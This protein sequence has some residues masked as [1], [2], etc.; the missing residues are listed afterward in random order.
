MLKD[1]ESSLVKRVQKG[2][3]FVLPSTMECLETLWAWLNDKDVN[4]V[5]IVGASG[6]GKSWMVRHIL[7]RAHA[8]NLFE[9]I[10]WAD[11][12]SGTSS[13]EETKNLIFDELDSFGE[14]IDRDRTAIHNV[15]EGKRYLLVLEHINVNDLSDIGI[16]HPKLKNNSSKLVFVG[17]PLT[18]F[19]QDMDKVLELTELSQI[20]AELLFQNRSGIKPDHPDECE[21]AEL[22][23][24]E[25]KRIPSVIVVLAGLVRRNL[26]EP[27]ATVI[28]TLQKAY[29]LLIDQS[30][31]IVEVACEML[32]SKQV[33]DCFLFSITNSRAS[34]VFSVRR[35]IIWWITEGFLDG[36]NCLAE[37]YEKAQDI[38]MTL[39]NCYLL[40][41]HDDDH[42]KL[43]SFDQATIDY[44]VDFE[45]HTFG[46]HWLTPVIMNEN[47]EI[48]YT[49]VT[50]SMILEDSNLKVLLVYGNEAMVPHEIPDVFFEKMEQLSILSLVH[51]GIKSLPSS[52]STLECLGTLLLKDCRS[53]EDVNQIRTLENLAYLR[54]SGCSSLTKLPDETSLESLQYLNLSG[55]SSLTKLPDDLFRNAKF[56]KYL[57][58]SNTQLKELPSSLYD[59]YFLK[60]LNLKGCS[61]LETLSEL[62]YLVHLYLGDC[63]QIKTEL[64]L[65]GASAF[66]EFRGE[67]TGK[68][69]CLMQVD[70]SGTKTAQLQFLSECADLRELRLK[71]CSNIETVPSLSRELEIL[72]LSGATSFKEFENEA[73]GDQ[74]HYLDLSGTQIKELPMISVESNLIQLLLKGCPDLKELPHLDLQKLEVLNLSGSIHFK[75]FSSCSL[76]KLLR[77]KTLDLSATQV[78]ELPNI[79]GCSNL[80][81]L[82]L[83][84]CLSLETLPQ[85]KELLKL[86]VLDLSGA[87]AFKQFHDNYLGEMGK[88]QELNL[89]GTQVIE[90]PSLDLCRNL[91][92]LIFRDCAKLETLPQLRA[93][94]RLNVLDL[95]GAVSFMA[96]QDQSFDD[97]D[98]LQIMDV[99][100]TQVVERPLLSGCSNLRQLLLR[101]CS[102]LKQLPPVDI[103]TRLEVL[104]LSGTK[105]L[106]LSILSGCLE[107]RQLSL[108][109]C[110]N[111]ETLSFECMLNLEKV[112]LS[113]TSIRM[114][115]LCFSEFRNLSELL[116][117]GCSNLKML[118]KLESLEKLKFLDISRKASKEISSGISE[119][120]YSRF[121]VTLNQ[122]F[123]W[124]FDRGENFQKFYFVLCSLKDWGKEKDIYLQRQEVVFKDVYYQTNHVPL[125][126]EEPDKFLKIC[127]FLTFPSGAEEVLIHAELLYLENNNFITRLSDLGAKH[128]RAMKECWIES[129]QNMESCFCGEEEEENDALGRCLQNLW[130]SKL[131]GLKCLFRD[132]VNSKSF[133]SL[134]NLYIEC[135]PSL[136]TVFSSH[137]E[138]K[139]LE[140]LKIKFCDKLENVSVDRVLTEQTF[141]R[142]KT[143]SLW[144][145]PKLQS[146]C[147]GALP[148]LEYLSV[149]RCPKLEKLPFSLNSTSRTLKIKG[150]KL[151]WD[152]LK[153]EDDTVKFHI[154]FTELLLFL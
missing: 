24:Q 115:P 93:L 148:S 134:K 45:I 110:S 62:T 121:L 20:E 26:S 153:C 82:V 38:S 87:S 16:S 88:L 117:K 51:T 43:K 113:G 56:I 35:L 7:D 123:L 19:Y 146:I 74:V 42:V 101:D 54:L 144:K 5:K 124:E 83:R 34:S 98:N 131:S 41:K 94:S 100:E 118:P 126:A 109:C 29:D 14:T 105:N 70:L 108:R 78:T 28:A 75:K 143:L 46:F 15:L 95:S 139:Q 39:I 13:V 86:E 114:L 2:N 125:L 102:K 103:L 96:F 77:L 138:L 67:S 30:M 92:K 21:V 36:C 61:H 9:F 25:C 53:L 44:Y 10:I 68:P 73:L 130:V 128:V 17:Y 133:T 65:S 91:V 99:S 58:L 129:C 22:L 135:C 132:V 80:R 112:D 107:L 79:S 127:G 151:W 85:L 64:D 6:T 84:N 141:P 71:N 48:A 37:A 147:T 55:C 59:L 12:G 63:S 106:D 60:T 140:T 66:T 1:G 137:L 152:K 47:L 50:K 31:S 23:L 136:I 90:V 69:L 76:G 116:L 18:N 142:L 52:L 81:H 97:K 145:L 33:R 154:D 149:K 32:P 72:D 119:W 57:D 40:I 104:N 150:E 27:S 11:G 8:S 3:T 89:S 122:N 4:T 49:E 120:T 111:M